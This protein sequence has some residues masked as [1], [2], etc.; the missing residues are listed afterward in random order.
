[1]C[2]LDWNF[3]FALQLIKKVTVVNAI[4]IKVVVICFYNKMH[5]FNL[6]LSS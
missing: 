5:N 6:Y 3:T 1:M 2:V 4:K